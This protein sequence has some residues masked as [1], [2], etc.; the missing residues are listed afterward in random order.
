MIH[1]HTW[2]AFANE[3]TCNYSKAFKESGFVSWTTNSKLA[4]NDIVY[5]FM[6]D[7]GA[8]RF[9]LRVAGVNMPQKNGDC[10][11]APT[12]DGYTYQLNFVNEHCGSLLSKETLE[13]VGFKG[14]ESIPNPGFNN[15]ELIED[16]EL[17]EY[18]N[19]L[20]VIESRPVKLPYHYIVVDLDSGKSSVHHEVFNL[21]ANDVDGRF[22]GYLPPHDNPNIKQ[23]GASGKED[24]VDGVMVVYVKKIPNSTNRQIIAF[25]DNARIYA[26]KKS[27]SGLKRII[28]ENG[29]QTEC[30]YTIESDYIYDLRAEQ[31][32]FV[33]P[34]CG[35]NLQMFRSQRFY[36]GKYPKLEAKM[37]LWLTDYLQTKDQD[38][39]NDFDFQREIQ[40]AE[41]DD[42]PTDTSRRQP[43]Y[44]SN[45]NT[46][47]TIIKKASISKQALK[48]ANFECAFDK[49]H[50]TFQ[51]NKGVPY[52]EG[53]HLIPCT[54]SNTER[55]WSEC[56]RNIDC[57]ENVICLCP[58][59]HRRIHFGSRLE[60]EKIIEPLFE[61]QK[62]SL[63]DAGL[64]ITKEELLALYGL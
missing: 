28:S 43:V 23:L 19:D 38:L 45:G 26:Q 11:I 17:V 56:E 27:G 63:E 47:K 37:L 16:T 52:M 62:S 57:V 5:L 22:Y 33:F 24:F 54:V 59:C 60:K 41:T 46:D 2:I 4:E 18:I 48:K 50:D 30:T 14:D 51:T 58:T 1:N 39:D 7:C 6:N 35:D 44:S 3:S 12:P 36:T 8:I 13:K 55:F 61:K 40:E 31:N 34:V 29:N 10:R 53:H 25:I 9:K 21:E 64:H 42:L 49:S 15:T 32:T 20:F